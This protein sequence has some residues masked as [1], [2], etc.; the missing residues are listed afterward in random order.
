MRLTP[1]RIFIVVLLLGG[2]GFLLRARAQG[3][4]YP[5]VSNTYV[6]NQTICLSPQA[7]DANGACKPLPVTAGATVEIQLPGT[8]ATWTLV[9]SSPNLVLSGPKVTLPNPG[10]TM[11]TSEL[12]VWDFAASRAGDATVVFREFPPTISGSAAG[13]F[14]YTFQVR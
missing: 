9:S 12:F 2:V 6:V 3:P 1:A 10:R 14:T 8:P 4:G 7:L 13:L 5:P 11:G